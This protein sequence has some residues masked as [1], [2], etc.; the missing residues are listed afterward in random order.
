MGQKISIFLQALCGM[1]IMT[2]ISYIRV[3]IVVQ[4]NYNFKIYT[5]RFLL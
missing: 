1:V 2:L 5:L 3:Y 4:G